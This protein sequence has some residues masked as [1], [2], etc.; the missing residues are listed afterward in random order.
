MAGDESKMYI[1]DTKTNSASGEKSY[2][3]L[4]LSASRDAA[5]RVASIRPAFVLSDALEPDWFK[6]NDSRDWFLLVREANKESALIEVDLGAKDYK[7]AV[8]PMT[9]K[10]VKLVGPMPATERDFDP[11]NNILTYVEPKSKRLQ[12]KIVTALEGDLYD[13]DV[14]DKSIQPRL[15]EAA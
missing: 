2:V 13:F 7:N 6:L 4:E 15:S 11:S 3:T 5:N 9:D 12:Q 14:Q 10:L 1:V 8:N